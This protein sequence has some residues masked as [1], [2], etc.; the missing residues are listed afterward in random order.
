MQPLY[1]LLGSN[2]GDRL[3]YIKEATWYLNEL[4]KQAPTR[5]SSIYE[6]AAWGE[7]NQAPFLNQCLLYYSNQSPHFVLHKIKNIEFLCGRKISSRWA[8]R[9]IDIDIL[10]YGSYFLDSELLTIPHRYMHLRAFTLIPLQEIFPDWV[11]PVLKKNM[12]TLC[13]ECEDHLSVLKWQ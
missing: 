5:F 7:E 11:H 6:T 13:S 3:K 1:L 12:L 2:K 8:A 9:E 10:I 4:F